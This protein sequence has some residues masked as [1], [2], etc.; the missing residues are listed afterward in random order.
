MESK[1]SGL[2]SRADFS[3]KSAYH[4]RNKAMTDQSIPFTMTFEISKSGRIEISNSRKA[5]RACRSLKRWPF[6]QRK[7][8][9]AGEV[10]R[11]QEQCTVTVQ[12]WCSLLISSR[13][14]P[15]V[16]QR[17]HFLSDL[18]T[19]HAC[20]CHGRKWPIL[21]ISMYTVP[22]IFSIFLHCRQ[23][24]TL[25]RSQ[26]LIVKEKPRGNMSAS[27]ISI[28]QT[29]HS[30]RDLLNLMFAT[31]MIRAITALSS[32]EVSCPRTGKLIQ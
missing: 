8:T 4:H 18:I 11:Y 29:G 9:F 24:S 6:S 30:R 16:S 22:S 14:S 27:T 1:W 26:W 32:R 31:G 5:N 10:C 21:C 13:V 19:W 12:S 2:G 7:S 20:C 15:H 25:M 23:S 3:I 28:K 17:I